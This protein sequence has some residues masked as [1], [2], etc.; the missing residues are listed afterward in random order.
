MITVTVSP[1]ATVIIFLT[2]PML[3]NPTTGLLQGSSMVTAAVSFRV[4]MNLIVIISISTLTVTVM[5]TVTV[6]AMVTMI[7]TV[8]VKVTVT[9][10]VTVRNLFFPPP[11]SQRLQSGLWPF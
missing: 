5:V 6:I 11:G 1:S 8:M 2:K 10:S 4:A 9:V 7:L 3:I